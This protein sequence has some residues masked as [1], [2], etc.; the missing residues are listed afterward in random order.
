MTI[1]PGMPL[2]EKWDKLDDDAKE[3]ICLQLWDLVAK[4]HTIAPPPK[5]SGLYQCLADGS[6]SCDPMLEDLQWPP[7]PLRSD[8][9]VRARIYERYLRFG[10]LR[11]KDKLPRMLPRSERS[12]FTHADIAPR[13]VMVDAE[14]RVTGLL[15]WEWAGWY[16]D[17]WEYAQIM[18]PAFK[19]NWSWWM[20]RTAP[21]RWDLGGDQCSE[22]GFILNVLSTILLLYWCVCLTVFLSLSYS[23]S[24]QLHQ[25]VHLVD[26]PYTSNRK[27]E[28]KE[29]KKKKKKE[30]QINKSP[31][32][33]PP[34]NSH[35]SAANAHSQ[36][37]S[38]PTA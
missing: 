6:P 4:I 32:P 22:E 30:K 13:N 10:G 33:N 8:A 38:P 37:P 3:S 7:R 20:E 12:V 36:N 31:N 24:C 18:R 21:R 9:D 25:H 28:K 27:R 15:G 5:L 19:G 2:T 23:G 35:P 16:P 14:N 29:K 34:R 1:A 11:Y 26:T 17:Y